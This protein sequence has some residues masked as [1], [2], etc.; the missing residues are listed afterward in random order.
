[1][2][3]LTSETDAQ[4]LRAKEGFGVKII[5]YNHLLRNILVIFLLLHRLVGLNILNRLLFCSFKAEIGKR[6]GSLDDF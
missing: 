1:M 5:T 3:L 6:K 4:V 2:A